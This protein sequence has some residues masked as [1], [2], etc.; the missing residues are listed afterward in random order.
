[1]SHDPEAVDIAHQALWDQMIANGQVDRVC[2]EAA[3]DAL[4]AAGYTVTRDRYEHAVVASDQGHGNA[5]YA[6]RSKSGV[7]FCYPMLVELPEPLAD[8][9]PLYRRIEG[10]TDGADRD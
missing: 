6:W 7:L 2:I 3:F 8:A 10:S 4:A 5:D 1:M 9:E